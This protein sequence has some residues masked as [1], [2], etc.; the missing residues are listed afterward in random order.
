VPVV[1]SHSSV[2]REAKPHWS[3]PAWRARQL[4]LEGAKAIA[5]KGGVVGLWALRT[6]VGS[7]LEGYA[8]RLAEM[9]DWLGEDHVAFG[10]DMNGLVGPAIGNYAD[11]R[12]VVDY[13]ERGGMS[14]SRI[15]K[16]AMENYA[17][18]LRQA[19]AARQ[20]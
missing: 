11:L 20:V 10:T 8:N 17:R 16:M 13:W 18:V 2:T 7:S 9:A 6:D 15:R 19:L 4:S 1:W 3:M 12:R 14:E 5:A